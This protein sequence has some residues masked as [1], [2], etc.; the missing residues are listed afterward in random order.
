MKRNISIIPASLFL[1]LFA[2]HEF[3]GNVK[4]QSNSASNPNTQ[5]AAE[6]T[7]KLKLN[8]AGCH[9]EG[10]AIYT[11]GELFHQEEH[12]AYDHGY[13]AKAHQNGS[14]AATCLDCHTT[15]GDMRTM[16][17][18]GDPRSTVNRANI[19]ATCG[20]CHGDPSVMNR[21]GI[22]NRPFLA[23]RESVHG[24]ALARGNTNAAVCTDCHSSHDIRPASD[25]QS[26]IFK[27]NVPATCGKCHA[28]IT[29][30]FRESVHGQAVARGVSRSPVCTDCHGIHNIKPPLDH[31]TATAMQAIATGSCAN[32]HQGV[33]LAQEYGVAPGR[34]SSYQDSYHGLATKLGSKVAANCASCHGVHNILP[35]SD[36]RSRI[37][38]NNLVQTCGQCHPGAGENFVVGKIHLNIPPEE[39]AG[40]TATPQDTGTIV[41]RWVRWIYISLIVVVISGMLLHNGLVWRR[42][43]LAKKRREHRTIMRMTV[44]QRIQHWLLLVSF[45]TLV[46]TGFALAYPTSWIALPFG[47]SE[48]LRRLIHRIAAVVMIAVGLYH[49]FYLA[50]TQ[51]G[52]RSL[53]DML[54]KMKDLRDFAQNMRHYLTGRVSKPKI[55]RFGYA[56]KAEYW[57]V[58]WGTL[59]MGLTGLMIWFKVEVFSFL[60]RWWIDVAIAVHFYEA[61]LATLA[62]FVWHFYHVIFDPDVY[63][64]NWAF[65]D[66]RMSEEHYRE[67]HELDYEQLMKERAKE[68][69]SIESAQEKK[70][71]QPTSANI[72]DD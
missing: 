69:S 67:E 65:L 23:Y 29:T 68:P 12:K 58:I 3:T 6:A 1:L 15:N 21:T 45:I 28:N 30:E 4:A 36:P 39:I 7:A 54:P 5:V 42:K 56:E 37:H 27:L 72:G 49:I 71:Y 47:S 46:I 63:P 35:S 20:K 9:A 60:P 38:P 62:I 17:P 55:A 11:G 18:A 13:H 26:A 22:S 24:R 64:I 34:V 33:A 50:L 8:C 31:E 44:N 70:E 59:I 10:K 32:C 40:V 48:S 25:P 16:L 14:K 53:R 61:V 2:A 52:R 43:A 41:T 51:E 57:A 19:T 66:G